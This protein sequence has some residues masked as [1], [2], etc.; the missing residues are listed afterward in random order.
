MKTKIII[1][2]DQ[3]IIAHELK[4]SLEMI[5]YEVLAIV[6]NA[7]ALWVL[8][9]EQCPD[10]ILLDIKI[11]GPLDGVDIAHIINQKYKIPFLFLT[12]NSDTATLQRVSHTSPAGF[13][14]K[15]FDAKNIAANIALVQ[16]QNKITSP[17]PISESKPSITADSLFVHENKNL[18][19][20]LIQDIIYIKAVGNYSQIYTQTKNN[21]LVSQTLGKLENALKKDTSFIIAHRSYI[22][23]LQYLDKI[24][25]R[26]VILSGK[27]IPI[28]KGV[29]ELLLEKIKT[30]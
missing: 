22:I 17:L 26:Q 23:N 20:V 6:S 25:H 21:P 14:T 13:I 4:M 9:E 5:G 30:I 1:V 18:I 27:E 19:R 12:A 3:I 16:A 29:H 24:E 15:P 10:L 11:D 2:E 8:L 7:A 28:S